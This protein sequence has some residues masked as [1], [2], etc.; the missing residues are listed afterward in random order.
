MKPFETDHDA[1]FAGDDEA[2]LDLCFAQHNLQ[3][4]NLVSR[5]NAPHLCAC[6]AHQLGRA[7]QILLERRRNPRTVVHLE[8]IAR[9]RRALERFTH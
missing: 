2:P 5:H 3:K 9:A 6:I 7:E 4:L 1:V 8:E